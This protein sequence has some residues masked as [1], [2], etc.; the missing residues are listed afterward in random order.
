MIQKDTISNLKTNNMPV[1]IEVYP[2]RHQYTEISL[3]YKRLGFYLTPPKKHNIQ[4]IVPASVISVIHNKELYN[5]NFKGSN[6]IK[7]RKEIFKQ[8]T[9]LTQGRCDAHVPS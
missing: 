1:W 4:K 8:I 7:K 6:L 2:K 5:Y 3:Y 9:Q